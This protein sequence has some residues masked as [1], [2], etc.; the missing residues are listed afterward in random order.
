MD[1]V[2]IVDHKHFSDLNDST[3]GSISDFDVRASPLKPRHG[4]REL[5]G[6]DTSLVIKEGKSESRP[7]LVKYCNPRLLS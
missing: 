2:L 1:S 6:L 4:K 5:N 3:D 7:R